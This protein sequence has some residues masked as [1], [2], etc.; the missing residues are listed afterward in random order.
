MNHALHRRRFLAT[1]TAGGLAVLGK[2]QEI[3]GAEGDWPS[4]PAV[5]SAA[6]VVDPREFGA[7]GDGTT[8]AT[9]AIQKAIDRVAA[10][11]GG[12]VRLTEGRWLSGTFYLADGV[13]LLLQRGAI[14]L[15]SRQ[16]DDY[17]TP[18]T[19]VQPD[20]T[21]I[22]VRTR[23]L[24]AGVGLKHVALRGEGTIDGQ[25]DAFRDRKSPRPKCIHLIDC[26]DVLVEGVR[27]RDAGSWMQHYRYCERLTIRG[28]DV[29]SHVTYNNDGLNIDSCRDVWITDCRVHSDDD[30]IVLKSLSRRP[31]ENV[32]ITHCTI[33]SHCNALKLGTESG[34]G[35]KNIRIAD[36][37]VCSPQGTQVIY[38]RQRGL[39][40]IALELV[41]GGRLENVDV[42]NL[43]IDGVSVAIFLR[44]GNRARLYDG[45]E[46]P[47]IGTLRNVSLHDITATNTGDIGCSITGLPDHCVENVVLR[48]VR[49]G[50][51]GGGGRELASRQIPER[52][53][54]YPESTMF[55]QL[56]AY[57]FF[58][59]H[60][61]NLVFENVSLSL[62]QADLRHA[63]VFDD[64]RNLTIDGLA[65]DS[66]AGAAPLM[67]L[68]DVRQAT[69]RGVRVP[70][71]AE[72]FVE[73]SSARTGAVSLIGNEVPESVPVVI[74]G[75]DVSE[76]AV[77]V[78][79]DRQGD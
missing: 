64:V 7:V 51:D 52:A 32:S 63:L 30:A 25:G 69:V 23:A 59:R 16:I 21:E 12:T 65:A 54:A 50:F 74:R 78:V 6:P 49:V 26:S 1:A 79:N 22:E 48:N 44:L 10:L 68:S 47:G 72:A 8:S 41:D 38:G 5:P 56:P 4:C 13:T 19:V 75:P 3:Q 34:G 60:A 39:A 9:A 33:S 14:L 2:D 11:G 70:E 46:K 36:C 57:G 71:T 42:S 62:N 31:C 76:H 24:I 28:I 35:F 55:G 61:R 18:R 67:R 15:G 77:T 45:G 29:F 66:P 43:D 58:C 20:G 27:M 17:G 37:Q 40:A 73:A 53:D